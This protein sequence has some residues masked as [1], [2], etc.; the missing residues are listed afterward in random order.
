MWPVIL[1]E[2]RVGSRRWT[3]YWLRLLGAGAV[4]SA[5]IFWLTNPRS[6]FGLQPGRVVFLLMHCVILAA[7]WIVVP[8]LVADSLSR[9]RR[10]G[11]LGLLFLTHLR[12]RDIV[13]A[14]ATAAGLTALTL[15][16]STIPLITVPV[17]LGGL[18]ASEIILSCCL[19]LGSVFFALAAGLLASAISQR[20]SQAV[21]L[22]LLCAAIGHLAFLLLLEALSGRAVGAGSGLNFNGFYIAWTLS[23]PPLPGR[24]S[25]A[26]A[27]SVPMHATMLLVPVLSLILAAIVVRAT[28]IFVQARWQD[29]PKSRRRTEMERFFC[30]PVFW[31]RLYR[32]WMRFSL[33][34]NPI[35]WLEKRGWTGRMT[36]WVWLA[37]MVS[38]ASALAYT[39]VTRSDFQ[40]YNILM[41][42]LLVSIAYVASGSFRRER[43]TGALELILVTPLSERHIIVGRLRALWSQ[44]LPAFAIWIV[45]VL[46]LS[47]ALKDWNPENLTRFTAS[48]LIVPVIGLYF[49]LRSRFVLLSWL[50]TL[51]CCFVVPPLVWWPCDEL[52]TVLGY[53]VWEIPVRWMPLRVW[54]MLLVQL[55][56]AALLLWRLR[57]NLRRRSF[58][59]R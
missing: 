9:E 23:A 21:A 13:F 53:D 7:I 41:W 34:R 18:P 47:T 39:A 19:A 50:A 20:T 5:V 58:S 44:F 57:V 33:E 40:S 2:L 1:R 48:Y 29:R 31:T 15:W 32:F 12:A 16:L 25:P 30:E 38:F 17:L 24:W 51:V 46:Y 49:S 22:A 4:M 14:K 45:V 52:L 55:D 3:T 26:R 10:E 42:M 43:E 37:V 54:V 8:L 11:T 56:L 36:A 59:F 35:G 28:A 6:F 27:G